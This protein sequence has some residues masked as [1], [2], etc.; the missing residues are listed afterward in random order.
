MA[1]FALSIHPRWCIIWSY[2]P[3]NATCDSSSDSVLQSTVLDSRFEDSYSVVSDDG[4]AGEHAST[5]LPA[6]LFLTPSII[7]QVNQSSS[8]QHKPTT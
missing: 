6:E 7:E 5:I 2:H 4:W 1:N 3:C 8:S